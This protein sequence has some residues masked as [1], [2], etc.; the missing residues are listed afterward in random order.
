M[1]E[2]VQYLKEPSKFTRLGGKLPKGVL[3]TGPPGTGKTLLARAIAG[4]A[5]VP[6]FHN[7]GS[8]FEEMYVGV[9][10]RRVRDL[11]T[12]ANA[13]APCIVFIDEIDAVGGSRN[14]KDQTA[15][16]MT[17]NQ[18][19]VEMDGFQQNNGVI[20]I[21]ATNFPDSLDPAL[22]R[23][24]RFDRHIDVPLPDVGGR[25]EILEL[26]AKS[27]PMSKEV[28]L[29]QIARGTPGFSG[30]E[31][32]NLMNQAAVKSSVLGFTAITMAMLEWA[33]DKITMGSE[34][35]S[36]ILTP[37]TMRLTA[38][39]EAGHALVGIL[40]NGADPIHKATII[41]RG[42]ALGLVL[43]LPDGDQTSYSYKQMLARL[44]VCMGGRIAEELVFGKDSVTSGASSDIQQATRLARSMVTKFGLSE[45]IGA[46][47]ISNDPQSQRDGSG[48]VLSDEMQQE[49]DK[50]IKRLLDESYKRVTVLLTKNRDKLENVAEGLLVFETIS[51]EEIV[52]L[53]NY[54]GKKE[55]IRDFLNPLPAGGKTTTG[56]GTNTGGGRSQ[57]PSRELRQ[58]TIG[59]KKAPAAMFPQ[60]P[61]EQTHSNFKPWQSKSN[62]NGNNSKTVLNNYGNDNSQLADGVGKNNNEITS[63]SSSSV[64]WTPDA[65]ASWWLGEKKQNEEGNSNNDNLSSNNIN[66]NSN[67]ATT[68]AARAAAMATA[69]VAAAAKS[70]TASTS[71]QSDTISTEKIPTN[72]TAGVSPVE[73]SSNSIA[74]P[75]EATNTPTTIS[76]SISNRLQG[77]GPPSPTTVTP[78]S[79]SNKATST[80]HPSTSSAVASVDIKRD[81]GS[82][83]L[84]PNPSRKSQTTTT[85]LPNGMS[86]K[87]T[88]TTITDT[89]PDGMQTT[90]TETTDIIS[91]AEGVPVSKST[92]RQTKK[93]RGPPQPPSTQL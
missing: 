60:P 37:E 25:K 40:T 55:D 62:S 32:F 16:K 70:A 10:A 28:N 51:G 13:N 90:T 46:V 23:P 61:P 80:K 86:K 52:K 82:N 9:G 15:M 29:E 77:R 54:K 59:K 88:T 89:S 18:L 1:E 39:H 38:T 3:L 74:K 48:S 6:F 91:N 36:A 8:E 85:S 21:G 78:S 45:K 56:S 84:Q 58:I 2:I 53:V 87:S 42:R 63:D 17:L 4:E 44:D 81:T 14:L 26:Y 35:H 68:G 83:P 71:E 12:A 43:Q 27:M 47:Y 30:A 11:F 67:S 66:T 76:R 31:L 93:S 19:L 33:K 7:S 41:P 50:E 5:D 49:V 20:V 65:I 22:V 34:R 69:A 24:G 72:A 57:K 92:I 73:S 75:G 79:G 64:G